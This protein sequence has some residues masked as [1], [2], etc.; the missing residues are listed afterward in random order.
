MK[1]DRKAAIATYKERKSVAGI[2]LVRCAASGRCWVGEA[3][4]VAT[5]WNR[6]SFE[7]R[8]GTHSNPAFQATW[9]AA[10]GDGFSFEAVER[11]DAAALAYGRHRTLQ[12]RLAHW[13]GV[14][15]AELL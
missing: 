13:R 12:A 4:D 2:F 15:G 6:I 10:G 1:A 3:P 14:L 7:L 9:R 8:H 5:I 11:I